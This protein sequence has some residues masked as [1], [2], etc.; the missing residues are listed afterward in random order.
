MKKQ[1]KKEYCVRTRTHFSKI[2]PT[3]FKN[4]FA[5]VNLLTT[6]DDGIEKDER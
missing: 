6:I 5:N 2:V 4:C 1:N 3:H